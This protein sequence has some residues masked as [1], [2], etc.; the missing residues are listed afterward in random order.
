VT[1]SS[2]VHLRKAARSHLPS[3]YLQLVSIFCSLAL[4]YLL[5]G[6]RSRHPGS[7]TVS[8]WMMFAAT[9][10]IIILTWHEY[11]VGSAYFRWVLT[12]ADSLIPFLLG[13]CLFM[14][15]DCWREREI[16]NWL[17]WAGPYCF[18]ATLAYINQGRQA[19]RDPTNRSALKGLRGYHSTTI[20]LSLLAGATFVTL[21]L[22]FGTQVIPPD[23]T[24]SVVGF[25]NVSQMFFTLAIVHIQTRAVSSRG[26]SVRTT[27]RPKG[28]TI[29]S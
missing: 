29:A 23:F 22:L 5:D 16:A 27:S 14:I 24:V 6:I 12:I 15:T 25:V 2:A 26:A 4:A 9:V 3:I 17:L 21:S 10:H 1:R 28:E 8:D 11:A 7:S 13:I 20:I 18:V 19:S